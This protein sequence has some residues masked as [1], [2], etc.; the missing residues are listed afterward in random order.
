MTAPSQ[1]RTPVRGRWGLAV[2]L[3]VAIVGFLSWFRRGEDFRGYLAVGRGV[4][5]GGDIYA[6]IPHTNI[7]TW[8][9]FFSLLCV[10]L[11]LLAIASPVL[12]SSLWILLNYAA[13]LVILR[14]LAKLIYGREMS[15]RPA[16]DT[17]A[18]SAPELLVPLLLVSPFV[19]NNFE[20]LQITILLFALSLGGLHLLETRREALG[21]AAIG[22]A[23]AIKVMPVVFLPYLVYRR[24][25]RAAA[26]FTIAILGYS[27]SPILVF[28]AGRYWD[29]LQAWRAALERGWGV[30]AEN[31][32][33]FA[34]L[35]RWLGHHLTLAVPE[36]QHLPES[37]NPA[38]RIAWLITLVAL[39]GL[40]LYQFRGRLPPGRRA[41][42]TEW[43]VVFLVSVLF[44]PMAWKHYFL[45]LLLPSSLFFA[46]WR[47]SDT[48]PRSRRIVGAVLFT[49]ALLG[50]FTSHDLFGKPLAVRLE[51]GSVATLSVLVMFGGLLWLRRQPALL[52]D[53][54]KENG[55]QEHGGAGVSAGPQ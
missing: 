38:V 40:V 15:L 37:G 32:A 30:G 7:N 53:P 28:G 41:T 31:Q 11:A 44:G 18:L 17:V 27:L 13:L 42:L 47:G 49:S 16:P 48:D 4:L 14:L 39:T 8:P 50:L 34:L 3:L 19:L 52:M 22:A 5:S 45:V 2:L 20:H 26:W 9:P 29:Y 12:A 43:S 25:W 46:I 21:A 36:F 33:I 24:R 35:D 55:E 6:V 51:M 10:P 1:V 23:V 54:G